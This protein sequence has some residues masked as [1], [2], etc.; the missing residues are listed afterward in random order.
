MISLYV[1]LFSDVPKCQ[2]PRRC[3]WSWHDGTQERLGNILHHQ[4]SSHFVHHSPA[5][6]LECDFLYR[7]SMQQKTDYL[8]CCQSSVVLLH[9]ILQSDWNVQY[10][11]SVQLIK[12]ID[13]YGPGLQ[14]CRWK[15][16]EIQEI[17]VVSTIILSTVFLS[18]K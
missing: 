17:P 11:N 2:Y 6:I 9:Y 10:D 5:Y 14:S 13:H 15:L 12:R 7:S 1:Y 18:I 16:N 3:V 8:C 4:L